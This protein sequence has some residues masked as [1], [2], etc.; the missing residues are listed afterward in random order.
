MNSSDA[1]ASLTI[2]FHTAMDSSD[3]FASVDSSAKTIVQ[4]SASE[5]ETRRKTGIALSQASFWNLELW[6]C[7]VVITCV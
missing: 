4:E 7:E 5:T 2:C 6:T 1:P 3:A